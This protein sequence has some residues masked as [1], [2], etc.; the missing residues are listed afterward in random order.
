MRILTWSRE[1]AAFG[2]QPV[3]ALARERTNVSI[4]RFYTDF[5]DDV[6]AS[7]RGVTVR[8]GRRSGLEA[9]GVPI[10]HGPVPRAGATGPMTSIYTRDPD[11]NLIEIARLEE[12]A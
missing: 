7:F 5:Q 6:E 4:D 2:K 3:H 10:I 11:G 9:L 1:L 8:D 12:Q